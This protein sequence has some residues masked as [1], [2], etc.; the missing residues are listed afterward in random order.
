[1]RRIME[2]KN[3]S[4]A[5]MALEQ[6]N[7]E[8]KTE[9]DI[10]VEK[11]AHKAGLDLDHGKLY[12]IYESNPRKARNLAIVLENQEKHLST[13]TE[14]Q[15]SN[16]FLT[17]PQTIIKVIRLGYANSVRGDIFT[18]F[19]MSTMKD[20]LYKIETTYDR[21][22][23]GAT[24]GA[25]TY[26]STADRYASEIML[27]DIVVTAT[28]TFTG[29]FDTTPIRP[30][31]LTVYK[32]G[33]PIGRDD[34]AGNIVGTGLTTATSTIDYTTGAYT[35]TFATA[36]TTANTLSIQAS[37]NSEISTNYE[38][39]GQTNINLVA[40]DYRAHQYPINFNWSVQAELMMQ[41]SLKQDLGNILI[42]SG[43][44][45]LKKELDF[46]AVRLA[47]SG[48]KWH[49]PV[50]FNADFASAGADSPEA[51]AQYL[52]VKLRQASQLTYQ[53]L[54]RGSNPTS[55]V[56]G[57]SACAYMTQIRS[58]AVDNTMPDVGIFKMGTLGGIPVYQAPTAIVPDDE[59]MCVYKNNR[60][61]SNDS[62]LAIGTYV[63]MY[64]TPTLEYST[65]NKSMGVAFYGDM[66]LMTKQYITRV[67]L[68]GLS[69]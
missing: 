10:L 21:T 65:F 42:D 32:D 64:K 13:L 22:A 38:Q 27:D 8:S 45:E 66:K 61:E 50:E 63:P 54:M 11:W 39:I 26:E 35:L 67:K 44:D 4:E 23:R 55:Y 2:S 29:T 41:S 56:A 69:A 14:T 40:Y 33:E 3:M 20:S 58:F 49:D 28:T 51:N 34:G 18:E 12:D 19:A 17:T 36:L 62:A 24:A 52:P 47:Y 53:A 68:N 1:M 57:P 15:V 59:I 9:G 5:Q 37:F 31:T 30:Y 7:R 60:E 6:K 48:S 25:V 16:A 43:S 46:Q